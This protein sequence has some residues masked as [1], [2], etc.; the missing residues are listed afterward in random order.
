MVVKIRQ[1]LCANVPKGAPQQIQS[2]DKE[3]LKSKWFQSNYSVKLTF[4]QKQIPR[5]KQKFNLLSVNEVSV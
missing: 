4:T 3:Q 1:E 5:Q 2:A